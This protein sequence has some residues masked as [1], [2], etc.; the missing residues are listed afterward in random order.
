M[1]REKKTVSRIIIAAIKDG[2]YSDEVFEDWLR[3][4][5]FESGDIDRLEKMLN[6]K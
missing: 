5:T 4:R 2:T 6:Q 1:K 3:T